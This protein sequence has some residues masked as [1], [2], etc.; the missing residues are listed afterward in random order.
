[1]QEENLR[2]G[3]IFTDGRQN[4]SVKKQ[5]CHST[6]GETSKRG[7]SLVSPSISSHQKHPNQNNYV[8][9]KQ[10]CGGTTAGRPAPLTGINQYEQELTLK[11]HTGKQQRGA[12]SFPRISASA[13]GLIRA[14]W[15]FVD[16]QGC[17]APLFC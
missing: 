13:R 15:G 14:A 16:R 5:C 6:G 4:F 1:V 10:H 12:T 9:E 2:N 11:P 8:N 3:N 7:W 17:G